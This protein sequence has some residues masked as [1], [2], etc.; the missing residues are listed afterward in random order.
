MLS[1]LLLLLFGAA[2]TP[3]GPVAAVGDPPAGRVRIE[4]PFPPSYDLEARLIHADGNSLDAPEPDEFF[5]GHLPLAPDAAEPVAA[6]PAGRAVAAI[7]SERFGYYALSRPFRVEPGQETSVSPQPPTRTR[8]DFLLAL[9]RPRPARPFSGSRLSATLVDLD[10][11]RPADALIPSAGR[12]YAVW[13]GLPA[14][15]HRLV[16][17]SPGHY[18]TDRIIEL[19]GGEVGFLEARLERRPNV[20]VRLDLPEKLRQAAPLE[21]EMRSLRFPAA[22]EPWPVASDAKEMTLYGVPPVDAEFILRSPPWAFRVRRDLRSGENGEIAFA[23]VVTEA[24]GNLSH[25]GEPASGIITFKLPDQPSFE[26]TTDGLGR[27]EVSL[28]RQDVYEVSTDPGDRDPFRR[29]VEVPLVLEKL[30]DVDVPSARHGVQALELGY[31]KWLPISQVLYRFVDEEG[32]ELLGEVDRTG[33]R[34]ELPPLGFGRIEVTVKAK[35]YYDARS[36]ERA[37]W[38]DAPGTEIGTRLERVTARVRLRF[39]IDGFEPVEGVEVRVL[40]GGLTDEIAWEGKSNAKGEVD[41]PGDYAGLPTLVR[42][43]GLAFKLARLPEPNP[44]SYVWWLELPIAE[45]E[46]QVVVVDQESRPLAGAALLLGAD[47]VW[48]RGKS[49]AWLLGDAGGEAKTDGQGVLRLRNLPSDQ[50]S[51]LAS[52]TAIDEIELGGYAQ[53]AKEVDPAAPPMLVV[54]VLP[55]E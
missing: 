8:A 41:V 55:T 5:S 14:G 44:E 1:A 51:L 16:V 22:I 3:A 28:W 7:H 18:L 12:V 20:K 53:L 36:E 52:S 23:P 32:R 11:E 45:E 42:A 39:A 25:G 26:V 35:G 54:R 49:L 43:P 9:D 6:L 48:I 4:S 30:I 15:I 34:V 29:L 13:Y 38:P 17:D 27:Y 2:E 31:A 50:L 47:L 40:R 37:L 46:T 21:L 10:K 19:P 33:K 24:F